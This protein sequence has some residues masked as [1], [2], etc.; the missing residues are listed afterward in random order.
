MEGDAHI[1]S[2]T[3]RRHSSADIWPRKMQP[4]TLAQR[5]RKDEIKSVVSRECPG[6]TQGILKPSAALKLPVL[7]RGCRVVKLAAP[8]Y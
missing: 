1:Q 2:G 4:N 6:I 5:K 7:G 8:V 3:M